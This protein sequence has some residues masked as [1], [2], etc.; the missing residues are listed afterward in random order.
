MKRKIAMHPKKKSYWKYNKRR[1]RVAEARSWEIFAE[2]LRIPIEK[3]RT[4]WVANQAENLAV[5]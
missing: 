3:L 2:A 5:N 1:W 4:Q